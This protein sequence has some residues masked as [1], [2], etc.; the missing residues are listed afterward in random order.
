MQWDENSRLQKKNEKSMKIKTIKIINKARMLWMC[1][2]LSWLF[3]DNKK[4][5]MHFMNNDVQTAC[6]NQIID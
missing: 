2:D 4:L 3:I 6:M 5:D 1:N